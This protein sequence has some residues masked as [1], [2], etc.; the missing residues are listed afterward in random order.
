MYELERFVTIAVYVLPWEAQL[1]RARLTSEGIPAV[2][3]DEHAAGIYGANAIGGIKLRVRE[4]DAESATLLLKTDR[5]L[6]ALYLVT[7]EDARQV[8]CP[9]CRSE[10][11]VPE[12][13]F[14]PRW[15]CRAC[16]AKWRNEHA[17]EPADELPPAVAGLVTVARFHNPWEA[18]LART[19]LES[20]GIDSCVLEERIPPLNL[21]TGE[22][23]PLS[24]LEVHAA[25]ADR[26]AELLASDAHEAADTAAD[27][28][29]E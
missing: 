20:Q 12:G 24:R 19:L 3:A 1:A 17:D 5:P 23:L 2:V 28:A 8:R 27:T 6:P 9:T 11:V 26:A 16:G 10:D 14:R 21:L 15:T 22:A 29:A 18:H 13:W 7:D 25:D 4:E